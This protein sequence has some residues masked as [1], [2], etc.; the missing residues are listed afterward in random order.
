MET[1]DFIG[2]Q[3]DMLAE[4]AGNQPCNRKMEDICG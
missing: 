3:L 4:N 1:K 2:I